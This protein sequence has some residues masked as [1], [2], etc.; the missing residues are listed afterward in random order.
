MNESV[1]ALDFPTKDESVYMFE[2]ECAWANNLGFKKNVS[3]SDITI[4]IENNKIINEATRQIRLTIKNTYSGFAFGYIDLYEMDLEN[5]L[6]YVGIIVYP[7][8]NRRQGIATSALRHLEQFAIHHFGLNTLACR[9]EQGNEGSKI[10]FEKCGY[11]IDC[12]VQEEGTITMN[13][14][15]S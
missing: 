1:I 8:E 7:E 9:I 13:K 4:F 15:I 3:L 14:K 6:G 11:Q 2:L 10:L 12:Q 5:K